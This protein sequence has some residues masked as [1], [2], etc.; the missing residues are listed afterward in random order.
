LD[1]AEAGL[2]ETRRFV[3][4]GLLSEDNADE[5][6][7]IFEVETTFFFTAVPKI[8]LTASP[9]RGD[10]AAASSPFALTRVARGA[11]RGSRILTLEMG[12]SHP[13]DNARVGPL[14]LMAWA[15]QTLGGFCP[16]RS[17]PWASHPGKIPGSRWDGRL[18]N[19][20]LGGC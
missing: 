7:C 8:I 17:S 14:T 18:P 5:N 13:E 11:A 16:V 9:R 20:P 2:A 12:K 6:A 15:F 10:G 4:D 19:E 3:L 1:C